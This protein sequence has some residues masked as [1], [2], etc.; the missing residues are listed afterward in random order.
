MLNVNYW[1][2]Q[3]MISGDMCDL[4]IKETDWDSSHKGKIHRTPEG[5]VDLVVRKTDVVFLPTMSAA[6]CILRSA[7][8]SANVSARWNYRISSSEPVQMGR[9]TIGGHYDYHKDL[10][11]PNAKNEQRKLSAVLFLSNPEDYEGGEFEFKDIKFD[12][13][14]FPRGSLIVFP[15]FL[16]HKVNP[17]ISGERFTAVCWAS[18][19]AFN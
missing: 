9:Y 16:D 10:A 5:E 14:K 3:S 11:P 12:Q 13:P 4:L 18:G 7:I 19:P 6:E 15:S 1:V 8:T 17:V 2:F